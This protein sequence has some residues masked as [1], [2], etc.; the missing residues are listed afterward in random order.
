MRDFAVNAH[1]SSLSLALVKACGGFVAAALECDVSKTQLQR[2]T[3]PNHPYTL[4]ASTIWHL[5][6]A[7]GDPIVSRGLFHMNAISVS[8]DPAPKTCPLFIGIDLA[9]DA[10]SL[11]A[12]LYDAVQDGQ[13]SAFEQRDLTLKTAEMQ[14]HLT[15]L[16]V[17]LCGT[18]KFAEVR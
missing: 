15:E 7:C 6:Q 4:K 16:D 18:N 14:S 17:T 1:L 3:D 9:G 13:I 12:T 11:T 5:E 2:A 10:S 8:V